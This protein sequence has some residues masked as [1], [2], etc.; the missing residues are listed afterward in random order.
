VV[1]VRSNQ[2]GPISGDLVGNPAASC[3]GRF[4]VLGSRF[5]VLGSRFSV[6]GSRFSVL[7]ERLTPASLDGKGISR[8][9][10][11]NRRKQNAIS[12]PRN[13]ELRTENFL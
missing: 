3:Q 4:S 7:G 2:S 6:L 12:R 10:I 11:K 1:R 9:R 8:K 5:S 13:G